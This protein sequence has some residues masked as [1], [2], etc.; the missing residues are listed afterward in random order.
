[1]AETSDIG[2]LSTPHADGSG[3]TATAQ[4]TAFE[5]DHRFRR[6]VEYAPNAM[7][8]VDATGLIE[9][10]NAETEKVFGY[11]R[12]ELLGQPV[13]VLVPDRF[14]HHHAGLRNSFIAA[15]GPRPMGPGRDLYALRKD[16]SEF[17]VEI[18]LNP[19]AEGDRVQVLAAIVDISDRK[20]RQ[21]RLEKSLQE[22]EI[23]LSE[24]HHRVK[25]NLQIVHSLLDM[26]TANVKDDLAREILRDSCNRVRSMA[27][28]HQTLYQSED[29][30]RVDFNYFCDAL[31]NS[32]LV[33]FNTDPD[34]INFERDL[35]SVSLPIGTAVP[36]GLITNELITNALKHAFP[37]N[38]MGKINLFATEIAPNQ[39]ELSLTD[40]G[41]GFPENFCIDSSNG[42]GLQLVELLTDQLGGTL[43]VHTGS[44]TRI[45][46]RFTIKD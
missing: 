43:E 34:R 18:G 37:G 38:R 30:S 8:L 14:R 5:E 7:I 16:G 1:M 41:V 29:V 40:D 13:D 19:I 32:L 39:I 27:Q 45:T 31:I 24:V 28:I 11:A 20:S 10:V 36:C 26:Q 4:H 42:L 22:K 12:D 25:N 44:P 2:N 46:I 9:M 23:L 3:S 17:P 21:E 15:P 33:T 35:G 6:V